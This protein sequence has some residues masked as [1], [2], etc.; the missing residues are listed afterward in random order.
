VRA[1]FS[2]RLLCLC[3]LLSKFFV[4][5]TIKEKDIFS[6]N[7]NNNNESKGWK[8]RYNN[9]NNNNNNLV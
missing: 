2:R 5:R 7:K 9:N 6:D 3:L 1:S 8:Y 4:E